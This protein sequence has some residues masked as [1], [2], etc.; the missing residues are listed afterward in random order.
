M[1]GAFECLRLAHH[2]GIPT[3]A[4]IQTSLMILFTIANDSNPGVAS[5]VLGKCAPQAGPMIMLLWTLIRA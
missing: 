3:L 2:Y 4:T 1:A 5:A